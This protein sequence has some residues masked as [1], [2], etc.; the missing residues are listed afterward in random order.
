L[1]K[2]HLR[3][4]ALLRSILCI[5]SSVA[6]AHVSAGGILETNTLSTIYVAA[7]NDQDKND[8]F[9]VASTAAQGVITQEQLQTR[10]LLRPAEVLETVPGL[11]VT[12]HSG[13]GKANQYFLRGF[14]LDHGTDFATFVAGIPVNMVSHWHGHRGYSVKVDFVFLSSQVFAMA[15]H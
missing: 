10:P 11:I 3:Q 9:G 2:P 1:N 15:H 7:Q 13:D 8:Q 6:V 12:Q 5:C 4:T 14:N